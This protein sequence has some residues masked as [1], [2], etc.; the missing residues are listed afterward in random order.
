ML[1]FFA[2]D[3]SFYIF[4]TENSQ[5]TFFNL[6]ICGKLILVPLVP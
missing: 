6:R 2:A 1:G 3:Y 5:V 4:I